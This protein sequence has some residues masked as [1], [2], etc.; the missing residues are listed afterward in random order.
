[1]D[2]FA[3]SKSQRLRMKKNKPN[4]NKV[5]TVNLAG[6]FLPLFLTYLIYISSGLAYE[7]AKDQKNYSS[8]AN[9]IS[10]EIQKGNIV[11]AAHLVVQDGEAIFEYYGGASDAE[12]NSPIKND[13]IV[14]IYSMSKPITSVAAM[15]LYEEGKFKL[16]D[17]ISK[18]IPAFKNST[19]MVETDGVWK[20]VKP[21]R[22]INVRDVFTHSTGYGYGAFSPIPGLEASYKK[23]GMKYRG[24]AGMFPPDMTIEEAANALAKI[25]AKHHPGEKFTYGFSTDLLGRLIEVWSGKSLDVYLRE[26]LFNPLGMTDTGFK[27]P[28]SKMNRFASCH[29]YK[30]GKQ[31]I[32]DKSAKS[33]YLKGFKFLSGGGGLVSTMEDYSKFCSMLANSG[34]FQNQQILSKKTMELIFQNHLTEDKNQKSGGFKFGLGF[35]IGYETFGNGDLSVSAKRY[36]W[37]GYASTDFHVVPSRNFYQIFIR[38]TIPTRSGLAREL[39]KDVYQMTPA[40]DIKGPR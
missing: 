23:Y 34:R 26:S 31:S 18:Y 19:V 38:Q 33:P 28:A 4:N 14:R 39:F 12:D 36:S 13:T 15:K 29:T 3:N 6:P 21:K 16:E 27:V 35:A 32:I 25:P 17:P 30:N 24:P 20:R 22:Q 2:S 1:M 10:E 7:K 40:S 37:G 9:R 5:R 8:I 11:G